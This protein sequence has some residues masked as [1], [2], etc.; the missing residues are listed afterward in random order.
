M[1]T[2]FAAAAT[3]LAY[4]LF[5]IRV[6]NKFRKFVMIGTLAYAGLLLVNIILSFFGAGFLFNGGNLVLMLAVSALGIGLAVFNLIL[7]FDY[8]EQ[9]IAM[10]AD[11]SESWRA[12]FGLTVTLV[13]LY[14]EMLRLLSYFRN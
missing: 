8:I 7:D 5:N 2:I 6:T 4:R 14:V 1:S 3:L 13:W 12:A 11:A 10:G 9:G